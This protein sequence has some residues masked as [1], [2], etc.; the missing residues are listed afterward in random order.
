MASCKLSQYSGWSFSDLCNANSLSTLQAHVGSWK[1]PM[2]PSLRR[3][4]GQLTDSWHKWSLS[5]RIPKVGRHTVIHKLKSVIEDIRLPAVPVEWSKQESRVAAVVQK[6]LCRVWDDK[7]NN[8]VWTCDVD[9]LFL[10]V[11]AAV[12]GDKSWSVHPEL[13]STAVL[14]L[15]FARSKLGL[16]WFLRAGAR[17]RGQCGSPTLF[18]FF[19]SKCFSN[20]GSKVC[21]KPGHSC[22]RRVLDSSTTPFA[23]GWRVMGRG[24]RT[25][26]QALGGHEVFSPGD[27][28]PRLQ[29]LLD[30]VNPSS[31]TCQRCSRSIDGISLVGVDIDQAF[32]ACLGSN[33]ASAW[34]W[35]SA[36]FERSSGFKYVQVK[37]SKQFVSRLGSRPWSRGW[38]LLSLEELGRSMEIPSGSCQYYYGSSR[39]HCGR[40]PWHEHW[41]FHVLLRCGDASGSRGGASV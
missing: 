2:W 15:A 20:C 6:S 3:L 39:G 22:M 11:L 25:V 12:S 30:T 38:W 27:A 14:S 8:K 10:S 31:C 23:S 36:K 26:V 35:A 16:P 9:Q 17:Q 4:S 5:H 13:D 40:A 32:E 7:L 19:T 24:V 29:K 1:L 18:P 21:T 34:Q 41:R 37:K 28:G 33:V